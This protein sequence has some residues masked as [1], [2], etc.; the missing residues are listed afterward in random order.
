MPARSAVSFAFAGGDLLGQPLD[1]H[2]FLGDHVH[3]LLDVRH[4]VLDHRAGTF[5]LELHRHAALDGIL[6]PTGRGGDI[7]PGIA[8]EQHGRQQNGDRASDN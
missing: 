1:L 2:L 3:V 4:E 7:A 5:D 6:D 8:A